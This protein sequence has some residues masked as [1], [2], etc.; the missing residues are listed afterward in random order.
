METERLSNNLDGQNFENL[1]YDPLKSTED[2]LSDNSCDAD[3]KFHSIN[4]KNIN[5]LYTIPENLPIFLDNSLSEGFLVLQLN[6]RI[7]HMNKILDRLKI[8]F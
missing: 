8:Q 7:K 5:T 4:M 6:I 2:T 3:L 1:K